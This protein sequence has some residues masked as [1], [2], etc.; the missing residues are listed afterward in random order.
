MHKKSEKEIAVQQQKPDSSD[1]FSIYTHTAKKIR[2]MCSQKSN[3]AALFPF[4][5]FKCT[6]VSDLYFSRIG[7]PILLQQKGRPMVGIYKSLT[8]H[9]YM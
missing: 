7:P 9:R 4:S 8:G 3:C 6:F 5:V 1:P 2:I